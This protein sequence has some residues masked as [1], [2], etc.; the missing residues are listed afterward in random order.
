[1]MKLNS[2]VANFI[3][4]VVVE[5]IRGDFIFWLDESKDNAAEKNFFNKINDFTQYLNR[6]CFM[7]ITEQGFHYAV[8]SAA[9]IL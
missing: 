8:L 6:T 3:N 4:E 2:A 9:H 1:M 5:A 7:G